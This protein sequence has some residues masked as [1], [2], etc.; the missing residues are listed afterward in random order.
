MYRLDPTPG[1]SL[2]PLQGWKQ[3]G[4]GP[5]SGSGKPPTN[6][7][8]LS[9]SPIHRTSFTNKYAGHQARAKTMNNT[10]GYMNGLHALSRIS[11]NGGGGSAALGGGG[12]KLYDAR[13]GTTGQVRSDVV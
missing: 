12:G 13:P 2:K 4:Q 1:G 10:A 7:S 6:S 9:S 11:G 5:S 3:G 8:K